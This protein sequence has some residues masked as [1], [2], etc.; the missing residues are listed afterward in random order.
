ME[1]TSSLTAARERSPWSRVTVSRVR[2]ICSRKDTPW[3]DPRDRV[4]LRAHGLPLDSRPQSMEAG[5]LGDGEGVG[6]GG[7]APAA[8]AWARG[9]GRGRGGGGEADMAAER[10]GLLRKGKGVGVEEH[11]N[12]ELSQR[13]ALRRAS[14]HHSPAA[15]LGVTQSRA[16][17][18]NWSNASYGVPVNQTLVG[19]V[20]GGL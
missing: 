20:T 2:P 19:S 12:V 16:A 7:A 9:D 8:P 6:G 18:W 5:G 11:P 1:Q 14:T 17:H 4:G 15:P 13:A 10:C 3:A